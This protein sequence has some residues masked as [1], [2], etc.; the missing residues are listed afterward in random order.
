[1]SQTTLKRN[2]R[3]AEATHREITTAPRRD[4][5]LV[6]SQPAGG[7]HDQELRSEKFADLMQREK[8]EIGARQAALDAL[9]EL[10]HAD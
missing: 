8:D 1:M 5:P 10:A 6:E 2:E 4:T 3:H 7:S 9:G